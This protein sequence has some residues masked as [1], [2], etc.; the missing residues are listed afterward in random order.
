MRSGGYQAGTFIDLGPDVYT[1]NF[2]CDSLPV[3]YIVAYI[4]LADGYVKFG[5]RMM[6]FS[7]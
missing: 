7:G 1:M 4:K 5:G 3:V 2:K 6:I